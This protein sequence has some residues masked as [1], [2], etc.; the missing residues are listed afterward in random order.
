[1]CIVQ[2]RLECLAS[3]VQFQC[4]YLIRN[5][6]TPSQ[7]LKRLKQEGCIQSRI[8]DQFERP[9]AISSGRSGGGPKPTEWPAFSCRSHSVWGQCCGGVGH[10]QLGCPDTEPPQTITDIHNNLGQLQ[11][12]GKC[13]CKW[14]MSK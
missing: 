3:T 5:Y 14:S 13:L 7:S 9:P 11:S 4:A 10:L 12:S 1:M 6:S 8:L 2:N